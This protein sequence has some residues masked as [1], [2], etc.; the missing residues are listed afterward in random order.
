MSDERGKR[1]YKE[2]DAAGIWSKYEQGLEYGRLSGRFDDAEKCWRFFEGDQWNGIKNADGAL[3]FYNFIRP[4]VNYK[5]ARIA[6]N[7]KNITFSMDEPDEAGIMEAVNEQIVSAWEYGKMD[8]ICWEAVE[9]GMVEG[10][11]FVYFPDGEFF[12]Q[13][14]G[15]ITRCK[16]R[17]KFVQTIDATQVFLGDE[18]E[19]LLQEQPYI[20]IEERRLLSEVL[21]EAEDNGC[22]QHELSMIIPDDRSD[23]E[24]TTGNDNDQPGAQYVTCILYMER[25][26]E[27]IC[28]GRA[29][30]QVVFQ[31]PQIIAGL[32]YYPL[33]SFVVARQKGKARGIG[34][35]K[36][37][38]PNQ[39]ET[40]RTL[41]RRA[42]AIKMAVFPKLVYSA[43]M[44][45]N[46]EDLDA[47]GARIALSDNQNLSTIQQAIGYIQ[48][49]PIG[50]EAVNFVNEMISLSKELAGAGDAALGNINPEQ[51]SG[52]AI[53]A[54]Q[55]Q[56]DIPLNREISAYHQMIEDIAI[57]W[58]HF[59]LAYNPTGYDGKAGRV[60]Q[61]QL[62]GYC[63]IVKVDVSS[64]IPD[65]VAAR[66]NNLYNLLGQ[67]MITFDEFLELVGN[68]SNLPIEKL[69]EIREEAAQAQMESDVALAD[70]QAMAIEEEE[71][72]ISLEEE[73]QLQQLM[74]GM[75]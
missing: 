73:A 70:A 58:Y 14:N 42:E 1:R 53:T 35:V 18:E 26:P 45:A 57:L 72:A 52:A 66:V 25:T 2:W 29:T 24:V 9:K 59:I 19:A 6:M 17:R 41:V 31:K 37:L 47:A 60:P 48:P 75:I 12:S 62:E 30:R 27:G 7:S 22:N 16:R 39:I 11:S 69:K 43:D 4:V 36:P 23:S 44:I 63:P 21:R 8:D 55:D 51:A 74:G 54:V 71:Q 61:A 40:N 13:A 38:I 67:Q 65:T 49:A 5:K 3:P 34:E 15:K 20:M 64:A 68:E 28:F 32:D 46:P 50:N 10:T 56:A 33:V